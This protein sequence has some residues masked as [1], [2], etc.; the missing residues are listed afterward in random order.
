MWRIKTRLSVALFSV[1][2]MVLC[3][4]APPVPLEVLPTTLPNGVEGESY[5]QTLWAEGQEPFLW[6]LASGSLPAGL[7]LDENNGM[8]FGI[9]TASGTYDF[10]VAV[11]DA[12]FPARQGEMAYTLTIIPDLTVDAMLAAARVGVAYS[13]TFPVSGGVLPYQ[14]LSLI[15]I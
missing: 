8:I 7:S 14:Y 6:Q 15:H 3:G 1:A 4:C 9:P 13:H 2:A 12:G 11:G 5:T 10:T